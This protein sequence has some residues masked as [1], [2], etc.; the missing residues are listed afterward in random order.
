MAYASTGTSTSSVSAARG[1]TIQACMPRIRTTRR[2]QPRIRSLGTRALLPPRDHTPR[3]TTNTVAPNMG[4]TVT[5]LLLPAMTTTM[6]GTIATR[7]RRHYRQNLRMG[8]M[9][10]AGAR[11]LKAATMLMDAPPNTPTCLLLTAVHSNDRRPRYCRLHHPL[12]P[13]I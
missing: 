9:T 3:E 10:W 1:T 11:A 2:R 8:T 12:R 6:G 5:T 13:R 4:V 7:R